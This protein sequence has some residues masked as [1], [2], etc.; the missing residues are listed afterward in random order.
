MISVKLL[1]NSL[2]CYPV[3]LWFNTTKQSLEGYYVHLGWPFTVWATSTKNIFCW[4]ANE[5]RQYIF[6]RSGGRLKV[7]SWST[8]N[9]LP[10]TIDRMGHARWVTISKQF[11]K[12]LNLSI[13]WFLEP[14]GLTKKHDIQH[15]AVRFSSPLRLFIRRH[16][17]SS[18]PQLVPSLSVLIRIASRWG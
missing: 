6:S 4:Q 13:H 14:I 16:L 17:F 5:S 12:F 1:I 2:F 8:R 3:L 15:L 7:V 9:V 18:S 10:I 11:P